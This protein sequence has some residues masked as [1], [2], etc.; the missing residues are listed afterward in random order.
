MRNACQNQIF[1]LAKKNSKVLFIGSDLGA[2]VQDLLKEKLPNQFMMEGVSEQ[3]IIGFAT[4]LAS[5]GYIPY[6]NTISTFLTRRCYEQIVI[7]ACLHNQKLRLI[8]NGGGLAYSALGP[9]HLAVDDISIMRII[10]NMTVVAVADKQEM[11]NMMHATIEWPYPIY[12]RLGKGGE[13]VISKKYKFK[14]GKTIMHNKGSDI[15]FISTGIM[16]EKCIE[17]AK[18]F[19]STNIKIGIVHCPTIQP[20]NFNEILKVIKKNTKAIFTFEDNYITGG[21][22]SLILEK[23]NEN[24]LTKNIFIKNFGIKKNFIS[25]YGTQDE[26]LKYCKLDVGSLFKQIKKIINENC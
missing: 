2:G 19:K 13:K 22:G 4:G 24:N 26:L 14:F 1:E 15:I 5:E 6:I 9:T 17:I 20:L 25:K 3:F 10:P 8:G 21:F 16:T 12:I 18:M 7:D 11:I 23:L